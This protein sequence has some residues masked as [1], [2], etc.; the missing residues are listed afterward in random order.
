MWPVITGPG[1]ITTNEHVNVSF[2]VSVAGTSPFTFQWSTNGV[3]LTNSSHIAGATT[4]TLTLTN[5][6]PADGTT[7]TI[8]VTNPAGSPTS[9]GLLTVIIPPSPTITAFTLSSGTNPLVNISTADI[10]DTTNSFTL[11]GTTN[12]SAP[13]TWSN[14][15]NIA[16]NVVQVT[17]FTFFYHTPAFQG[18]E[19]YR[20]M[21]K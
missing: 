14:L 4:A 20:I 8:K 1:N 13:I 2:T 18:T 12:L 21:H 3:N 15:V 16:C 10:Y 5:I 19:F 17:N 6:Q 7:Y 9:S 11:Q